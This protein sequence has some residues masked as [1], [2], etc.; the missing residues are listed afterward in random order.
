VGK[1]LISLLAFSLAALPLPAMADDSGWY[2]AADLG[3]AHYNEGNVAPSGLCSFPPF[4]TTFSN[5]KLNDTG[6]RLS[7]GYQFDARWGLEAGYAG[8]GEASETVFVRYPLSFIYDAQV[9]A[10]GWVVDGTGSLPLGEGWSI[11]GRLGMIDGH[12]ETQAARV[13]SSATRWRPTLGGSLDWTL[14][15]ELGLRL[16]FDH[17]RGL[18]DSATTGEYSVNLITIGVVYRFR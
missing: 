10:H 18:G 1:R 14:T 7:G 16:N 6:Y 4:C 8:F 13:G 11:T 17:Y 15:G 2:A 12:V 5:V 3:Q 9:K